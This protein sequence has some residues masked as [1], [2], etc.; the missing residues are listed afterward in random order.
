MNDF[1][2][3]SCW[4]GKFTDNELSP[5]EEAGLLSQASY[6]PLLRNELRLDR[7]INDLLSDPDRIKLSENIRKTISFGRGRRFIPSWAKIAA[8][9][10]LLI[11]FSALGLILL[12]NNG[13]QYR[14]A[15]YSITPLFKLRV[16]ALLGFFPGKDQILASSTPSMRRQ[17]IQNTAS[18]NEYTPRPE[19]E[20]LV[21]SV[22]RDLSVFVIS[23]MPRVYCKGDSV[24]QFSWK[25]LGGYVPVNLE[26][27]DNQGRVVL[28]NNQITDVSYILHTRNWA[29]GLYYYKIIAADE[30]VTVGS[31]SIY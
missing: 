29:R 7:D 11:S 9:V 21:G 18:D 14:Q 31:I 26:I 19:Y 30:L 28:K 17:L 10:I 8:A 22:T 16:Q 15:L 6:N 1:L 3:H 5:E 13:Q 4:I 25:W 24:L 20:F 23:P 12:T 2:T 27:T